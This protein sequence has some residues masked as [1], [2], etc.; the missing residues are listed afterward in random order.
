MNQYATLYHVPR[1]P[2]AV[3]AVWLAKKLQG[4]NPST[5]T[6]NLQL[7]KCKRSLFVLASELQAAQGKLGQIIDITT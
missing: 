6:L 1:H 3:R 4:A 7:H 5:I 2:D